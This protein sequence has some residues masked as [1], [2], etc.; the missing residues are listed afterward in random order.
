MP[1]TGYRAI[2]LSG[3]THPS[4]PHLK[5]V[6]TLYKGNYDLSFEFEAYF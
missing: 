1:H 5:I 6:R 3:L 2:C 4:Q